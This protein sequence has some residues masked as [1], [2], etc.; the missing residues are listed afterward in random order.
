MPDLHK[1]VCA[2]VEKRAEFREPRR[3]ANCV[4][5]MELDLDKRPVSCLLCQADVVN[6][7]MAAFRVNAFLNGLLD[8]L[9]EV[10]I[11]EIPGCGEEHG[12]GK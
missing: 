12:G 8:E 7:L 5:H 6:K 9:E 3:E 2:I 1:T 11:A 10:G 4:T